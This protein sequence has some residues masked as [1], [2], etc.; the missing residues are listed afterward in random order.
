MRVTFSPALVRHLLAVTIVAGLGMGLAACATTES[1]APTDMGPD[2][3]P[4]TNEDFIVNVGRR[5]YFSENSAELSD[6]A[7]VTLDNQAQWLN[8]FTGYKVKIEGFA[9]E[10]GSEE[11]NK[12]LGL[13][14]AESARTYLASKGVAAQRMRVKSFG[15]TRKVKDCPDSGCTSQNRRVITVLDTEADT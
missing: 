14:R 10:K 15:N 7:K 5:I 1:P 9:D 12:Q 8:K 2:V 3:P 13:K 6:T 4:G 11:F